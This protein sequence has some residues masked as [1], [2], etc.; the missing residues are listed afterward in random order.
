[1]RHNHDGSDR[2]HFH[3]DGSGDHEGGPHGAGPDGY[4]CGAVY[5]DQLPFPKIDYAY[6]D[7]HVT[8]EQFIAIYRFLDDMFP[9]LNEHDTAPDFTHLK[10][11]EICRQFIEWDL[12]DL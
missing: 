11:R 7:L 6:E 10:M 2:W 1:M 9:P 3:P 5:D 8:H 4:A 12:S